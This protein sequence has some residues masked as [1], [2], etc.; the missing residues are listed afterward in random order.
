MFIGLPLGVFAVYS[1]RLLIDNKK[2]RQVVASFFLCLLMVESLTAFPAYPFQ[3]DPE[4][5]YS[6]I[7]QEIPSGTP[8]IELPVSG[9]D[10]IES[11]RIASEQLKESTFY[12]GWLVTGYGGQTTPEFQELLN[13]DKDVQNDDSSP[14]VIITFAEKYKIHYLL[15][16]FDRYNPSVKE[17]WKQV[18]KQSGGTVIFQRGDTTFFSLR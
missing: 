12:W 10:S 9:K 5:V 1:L 2:W 16:H 8:L 7:S 4:G 14:Q 15:I 11:A 18:L 6:S 13:L 3:L 17:S